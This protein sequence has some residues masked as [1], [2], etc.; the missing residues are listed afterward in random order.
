[1]T[2]TSTTASNSLFSLK[3]LA[4]FRRRRPNLV[5]F[6]I[7]LVIYLAISKAIFMAFGNPDVR[8]RIDAA[9]LINSVAAVKVHVTAAAV[10]FGIGLFLLAGAKGRTLHKVLGY[11]WV[12]AMLS[13]AVSS[14]FLTGLNGGN[15]SPIHGLSA[16]VVIGMP[17]AI[18]A[19]RRRDIKK[20]SKEMTGMFTGGM[21]VAGLFSFL[22]GRMMWS[23]FFAA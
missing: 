9:Q 3:G 19:A 15:F 20:H 11:T 14:F 7:A 6:L 8:F 10:S 16:W 2:D 23:I 13:T 22:P 18:A 12:A 1:M 21:L 5:T 17:F 4:D